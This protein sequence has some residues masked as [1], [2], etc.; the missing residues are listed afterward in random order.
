M[1]RV[2][3]LISFLLA[4]AVVLCMMPIRVNAASAGFIT[5]QINHQ[6]SHGGTGPLSASDS[7]N[8]V[9]VTG[10]VTGATNSLKL[11]I[12]S[13]VTVVWKAKYS[14]NMS[15]PVIEIMGGGKFEIAAGSSISNGGS[16]DAIYSSGTNAK[17]N[18]SG[19]IVSCAAVERS[20]IFAGGNNSEIT[21]SG[22]TLSASAQNGYAICTAGE[23]TKIAVS[24]G[25]LRATG[26]GGAAICTVGP[27]T[28]IDI[29]GGTVESTKNWAI[30]NTG[31][32][33]EIKVSNGTVKANG[34]EGRAI[35]NAGEE[36]K[37]TVSGGSLDCGDGGIS[38]A[39]ATGGG[40]SEI[41]VTNGIV[42]ASGVN[43]TAIYNADTCPDSKI[44]VS[45]GTVESVF[46]G[47]FNAGANSSVAVKGGVVSATTGNAI[48]NESTNSSVTVSGGFVF[49]YGI[50]ISGNVSNTAIRMASGFPTINGT[51][52]VCAFSPPALAPAYTAGSSTNLAIGPSA[53]TATWGKNGGQTGINY[54]NGA[55]S[56]FFPISG[57][58][59]INA[60]APAAPTKLKATVGA[61]SITLTWKD[62]SDDETGFVIERK[63]GGGGWGQMGYVEANETTYTDTNVQVG[64]TY[65]YRVNASLLGGL[66][67]GYSNE[68][69]VTLN[70][71][72]TKYTVGHWKNG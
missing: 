70:S 29:N 20:A 25:M 45:G 65:T 49:S 33:S 69:T 51:A 41:T 3:K 38:I 10:D 30:Y 42:R 27:A 72:A 5:D 53:A 46:R 34:T 21:V 57:G 67:S 47:I 35:R 40:K 52:V 32:K 2:N 12:D 19:G 13:D 55:N 43:S 22:G 9:T 58:I 36:A 62:Y 61:N 59:T 56:G 8:I 11:N 26:E 14:G 48:Q 15:D 4:L 23:N 24:G 71:A 54:K 50:S 17:I 16:G 6:F 31:K 28:A 44:T 7:G 66:P 60:V 64:K 68:V 37:I 63:D 18:A 39:N 1:K